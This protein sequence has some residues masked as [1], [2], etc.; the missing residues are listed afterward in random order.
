M[1]R[2]AAAAEALLRNQGVSADQHADFDDN[3]GRV[4]DVSRSPHNTKMAEK[5]AE[6]AKTREAKGGGRN[7]ADDF[8]NDEKAT[9]GGSTQASPGEEGAGASTTGGP[10][11]G[12]AATGSSFATLSMDEKLEKIWNNMA[13]KTDILALEKD[14]KTIEK[15]VNILKEKSVTKDEFKVAMERIEDLEMDLT[16][17]KNLTPDTDTM[18][19]GGPGMSV[20]GSIKSDLVKRL[21]TMEDKFKKIDSHDSGTTAGTGI[22]NEKQITAV[23]GGLGHSYSLDDADKYIRDQLWWMKGPRIVETYTKGEFKGL[24][25]AK[26]SSKAE[27][28]AAVM[29]FRSNKL[30][31]G[32]NAIWAKEDL[33]LEERIPQSFL[34]GLK[35]LMIGW[36][37]EKMAVWVDLSKNQLLVGTDIV[38]ALTVEEKELKTDIAKDW[39]DDLRKDS[40]FT[41]LLDESKEKLRL[42]GAATKGLGKGK[43]KGSL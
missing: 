23:I 24:V 33:P 31:L 28:D 25:F 9:T 42:G 5:R 15:D 14:M 39:Q 22:L 36:G 13:M 4:R 2:S 1:T 3:P 43:V 32:G 40:D 26:F 17:L 16:N 6:F 27:R 20:G 29:L 38:I 35:K 10:T 7:L 41:K 37:Y 30:I 21:E 19:D 12:G 18:M 8:N 34:F 11:T